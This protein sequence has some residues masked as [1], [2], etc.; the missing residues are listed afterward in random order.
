[1]LSWFTYINTTHIVRARDEPVTENAQ[2]FVLFDEK[3]FEWLPGHLFRL[4]GH[5]DGR[6]D[7]VDKVRHLLQQQMQRRAL[8]V[9]ALCHPQAIRVIN[10]LMIEAAFKR[11]ISQCKA[12]GLHKGVRTGVNE[13]FDDFKKHKKEK[14][15]QTFDA[16]QAS[17]REYIFFSLS[18][19]VL[20]A[21]MAA[22]SKRPA[23]SQRADALRPFD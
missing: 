8:F 22:P 3:R 10:Q 23:D 13:F 15:F 20:L 4:L 17:G 18:R 9:D 21:K 16:R 7:N 5:D 11:H 6:V 19:C 14:S 12:V 2:K 1:M